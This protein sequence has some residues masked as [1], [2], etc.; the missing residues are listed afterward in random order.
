MI[1]IKA[2]GQNAPMQR[3]RNAGRK[4]RGTDNGKWRRDIGG[5][6]E[7]RT[8]GTVARCRFSRPVQSTTLPRFRRDCRTAAINGPFQVVPVAHRQCIGRFYPICCA[9]PRTHGLSSPHCRQPPA[10]YG[11]GTPSSCPTPPTPSALLPPRH[12]ITQQ[13]PQRRQRRTPCSPCSS[14]SAP[15]ATWCSSSQ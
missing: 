10:L 4:K 1:H 6:G 8:H 15:W 5:S 3:A 13:R 12:P 2:S 9:I 14:A 11:P 7:I